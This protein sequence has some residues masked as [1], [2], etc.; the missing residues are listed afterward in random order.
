MRKD[1]LE[2]LIALNCTP[3][4][5]LPFGNK[6]LMAKI[7]KYNIVFSFVNSRWEVK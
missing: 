5:M 4:D 6:I 1:I 3:G 7:K 2:V